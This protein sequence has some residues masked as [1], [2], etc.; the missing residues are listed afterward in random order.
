MAAPPEDI[1]TVQIDDGLLVDAADEEKKPITEKQ[2]LEQA[3]DDS[4]TETTA[5]SDLEA[6]PEDPIYVC[7]CY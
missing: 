2:G 1:T 5:A 7:R 6:G 4:T 3:L